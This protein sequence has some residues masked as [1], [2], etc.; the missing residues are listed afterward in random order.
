[1]ITEAEIVREFAIM[2]FTCISL[3]LLRGEKK[4]AQ[5]KFVF[6]FGFDVLI[7]PAC[8]LDKLPRVPGV[9]LFN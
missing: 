4:S 2:H 1:M 3:E 5:K 7:N 8:P 9:F 6:L